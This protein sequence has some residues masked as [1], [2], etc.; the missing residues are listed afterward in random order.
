MIEGG[1]AFVRFD[2]EE[3]MQKALELKGGTLGDRKLFVEMIN[4][5]KIDP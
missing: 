4:K 2:N 1:K 3:A 5:D